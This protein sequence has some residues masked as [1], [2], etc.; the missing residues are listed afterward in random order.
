MLEALISPRQNEIQAEPGC[1]VSLQHQVGLLIEKND[2][3][4]RS[5]LATNAQVCS[6]Y[7]LCSSLEATKSRKGKAYSQ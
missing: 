3:N 2:L 6:W 4:L 5:A 7:V 1:R